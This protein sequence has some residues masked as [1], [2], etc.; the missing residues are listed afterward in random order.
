MQYNS[1]QIATL[2][3][4]GKSGRDTGIATGFSH[5]V[6]KYKNKIGKSTDLLS[7]I[8]SKEAQL[9]EERLSDT[10]DALATVAKV[11][12]YFQEDPPSQPKLAVPL[13]IPR[14]IFQKGAPS[15]C[16]R[17]KAVGDLTLIRFLLSPPRGRVHLPPPLRMVLNPAIPDPRCRFLA[18]HNIAFR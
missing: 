15:T 8:I 18:Q 1:E 13:T 16:N 14:F 10:E 4:G 5:H 11:W 17:A 7:M 3:G 2:E 6:S 12:G 9:D